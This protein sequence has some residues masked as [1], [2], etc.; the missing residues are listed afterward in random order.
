MGSRFVFTNR[1]LDGVPT[2]QRAFLDFNTPEEHVGHKA[3]GK[4]LLDH[5]LIVREVPPEG[6]AN[7]S[8]VGRLKLFAHGGEQA[9]RA[10]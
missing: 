2:R 10:L 1:V 8:V 3:L 6:K 7:F 4:S 9:A 5:V